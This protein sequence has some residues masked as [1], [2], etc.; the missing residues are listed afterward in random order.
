MTHRIFDLHCDTAFEMVQ[1]NQG[2]TRNSLQLDLE[3]MEEYYGYIQVFAAFVDQKDIKVSPMTHCMAL[4]QKM[5]QEIRES[6]GRI[7]LIQTA[8]EL[9]KVA[10]N[11]KVGAILSL[12]G[13][14]ALEGDL[15]NLWTYYRFGVRLITLTWNW[16]NEIADGVMESRGGGLTQFGKKAVRMMEE[17]GILIDVSHISEQGFWDVADVTTKPFVA[18][19]SCVKALCNHPRN[20]TDAQISCLIERRGGIGINFYPEFLSE[21]GGCS[22]KEILRHME[23][24]LK[25]GGENVLGIGSDFDGISTLP[26]GMDGAQDIKILITAMQTEAWSDSLI[27]KVLFGNFYRIF[28][29]TLEDGK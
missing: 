23:H 26:D 17:M 28:K 18:S 13:G 15:S 29:E 25:L 12:E 5:Q 21:N 20:L 8:D 24:I 27:Q 1:K 22:V 7:S 9:E 3:R 11:N 2:L 6:Q 19:H 14:E 4:I 16:A 10:T